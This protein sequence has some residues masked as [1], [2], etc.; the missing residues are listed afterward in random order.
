MSTTGTTRRGAASRQRTGRNMS[1]RVMPESI[2]EV[3]K[4]RDDAIRLLKLNGFIL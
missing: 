2:Y 4:D 1:Q 3:A